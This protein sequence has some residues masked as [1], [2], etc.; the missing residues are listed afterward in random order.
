MT[1]ERKN[2]GPY[3]AKHLLYLLARRIRGSGSLGLQASFLDVK[4]FDNV[5]NIFPSVGQY[6]QLIS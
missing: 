1:D 4:E 3:S 5:D 6:T 2:T